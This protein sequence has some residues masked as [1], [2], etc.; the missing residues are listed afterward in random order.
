MSA[1]VLITTTINVPHVL[2]DYARD[3]QAH[4]QNI[5]IIVTGDRKTP[6]AAADLCAQVERETKI[7]CEYM[8][9]QAQAAWMRQYP[10]L[11]A[12]LPW[13]CVQR[14]NVAILKA[15]ADGA[16]VVVTIDDDNFLACENYFAGH[17][18]C[19]ST[20]TLDTY[21]DA[22]AWFNVCRFL[23]EE[24]GRQFFA[25]GYGIAA[26][27]LAEGTLPP[28]V[29]CEKRIAVNAGLWLGDPDIDAATRISMPINATAYTR[30]KQ[31]NFFVASGA[32]TPFNSQ[33]T[34]LAREVLP[35]YFLSPYVGRY[36]D[37]FISFFVKRIADH[38]GQGISFGAPLVRQERNEHNLLNDLTLEY[39]GTKITDTLITALSEATLQGTG[40][41]ECLL[42]LA[43][44]CEQALRTAEMTL[45][46]RAQMSAFFAGCR[47]WATLPLWQGK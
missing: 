42:E 23:Q 19:G 18:A 43:L 47:V 9:P 17:A 2:L 29:P 46:E 16:E 33:N 20:A 36:D 24:S 37:I 40:Y 14:R 34:A 45:L 5:K 28:A 8:D 6:V 7:A 15:V 41:G 4:G 26:R 38:L 21:G 11:D 10:L 13:D 1:T 30:D 12:H 27:R 44:H 39:L 32:W 3:A 25:R 31:E 35:A 22:G